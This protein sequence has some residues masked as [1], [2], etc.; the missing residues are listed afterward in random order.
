[1]TSQKQ[2]L[3]NAL[4]T[5]D[6]EMVKKSLIS[7]WLEDINWHSENGLFIERNIDKEDERELDILQEVDYVLNPGAYSQ[8]FISEFLKSPEAENIIEA[9]RQAEEQ[10]TQGIIYNGKY[11][12]ENLIL[13]YRQAKKLYSSFSALFGWGL[14]MD[15]WKATK[16]ED[17]VAELEDL[18]NENE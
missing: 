16:G 11:L 13:D 3:K 9:K 14:D 8:R 18:L 5:I 7:Q 12:S 2:A 4:A 17:F 1:M 15:D 6:S 10:G